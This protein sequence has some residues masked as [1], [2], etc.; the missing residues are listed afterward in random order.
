ML[1]NIY[2]QQKMD[3]DL[4]IDLHHAKL[5]PVDPIVKKLIF[6]FSDKV[7]CIY[8]NQ[9]IDLNNIM[10]FHFHAGR[11]AAHLFGLKRFFLHILDLDHF[12]H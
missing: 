11:N 4:S 7:H 8:P 10:L 12:L 3:F 6:Y 2:K 1:I 5:V 9:G